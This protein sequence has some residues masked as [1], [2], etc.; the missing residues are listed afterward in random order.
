MWARLEPCHDT[1]LRLAGGWLFAD[2][3]VQI[4]RLYRKYAAARPLLASVQAP[5]SQYAGE[6]LLAI[7]HGIC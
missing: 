4:A 6:S 3:D 7:A 1:A 5:L 2:R